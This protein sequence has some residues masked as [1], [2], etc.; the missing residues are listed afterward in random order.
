EGGLAALRLAE[1]PE[2][3]N[4]RP[5]AKGV[6][7]LPQLALAHGRREQPAR[8]LPQSAKHLRSSRSVVGNTA[9]PFPFYPQR[10]RAWSGVRQCF[11]LPNSRQNQTR[12]AAP[13]GVG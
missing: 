4:R 6:E 1:Q 9:L 2:H 5:L 3:G 12:L 7:V 8:S 10:N 11:P 13:V